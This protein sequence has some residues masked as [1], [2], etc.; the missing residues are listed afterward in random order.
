MEVFGADG[1]LGL[2]A[3]LPLKMEL[4]GGGFHEESGN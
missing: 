1:S 3:S 4:I 2:T